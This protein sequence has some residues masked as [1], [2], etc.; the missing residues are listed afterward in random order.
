MADTIT[1]NLGLTKPEIGAS[2]DSWGNKINA[3]LDI[4]DTKA[5]YKTS[6]WNILLGDGIPASTGGPLVITRYNNS[7]LAIDN[8]LTINRQTGDISVPNN[9]IVGISAQ[10]VVHKFPYTATPAAPAAGIANFFVDANGNACLQRPDGTVQFLGVPPGTIAWTC[11][12]STDVGW[13]ICN[14]QAISRAANPYLFARIGGGYGV[15]DGS[16][17]F[18]IPDIRGRVISHADQ[19]A[20]LIG[21]VIGGGLNAKGGSEIV[22]LAASQV[23]SLPVS[24]GTDWN[25]QSLDH[26]HGFNDA[27]TVGGF[28]GGGPFASGGPYGPGSSPNNT[29]GANYYANG[30]G[31]GHGHHTHPVSGTASGGGS[32]HSN[33]PPTIVLYAQ[34]K[35]G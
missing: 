25:S 24:G 22:Y 8:P 32:W 21:N 19:G 33:L 16:T 2:A 12:G 3:D 23:P 29:G 15:G 10:A 13:T 6:Q 30:V 17:T 35:L 1:P 27:Q 4:L 34:I 31:G 11:A 18:N 7:A 20:G 14:G 9:L 28:G 26:D 5:V